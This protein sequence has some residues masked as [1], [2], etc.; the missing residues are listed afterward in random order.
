MSFGNVF[1]I[2]NYFWLLSQKKKQKNETALLRQPPVH[3]LE[4]FILG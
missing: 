3:I 4:F 2:T 1:G